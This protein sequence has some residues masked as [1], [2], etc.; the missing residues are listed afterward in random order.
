M[1]ICFLLTH[2]PDP[3][4]NKRIDLFKKD[5]EV[6]VVCC[7]RKSQNIWNPDLV[8]A[9]YKIYDID[10]PSSQKIF[11]RY[12]M[13][14][15]FRNK[16]LK[17]LDDIR[18]DV[19]YTEGLD[20]LQ[21]AI[22]YKKKHS[23]KS[24]FYEVADLRESY[25][26]KPRSFFRRTIVNLILNKEKKCFSSVDYLVLTSMKFYDAHYCRLIK[27]N[28]VI[29]MPN[30]PDK[31]VFDDYVKKT[32]GTFTVGFIGGIRYLEQMKML[33][34]A[35]EVVGCKVL[36][37]GVGGTTTDFDSITEYCKNKKGVVFY[38]KYDYK[39]EIASIY[40]LVDCVYAVYDADNPNVRIALPN[41]LYESILCRLPI[42]VSK[43][44][45]LSELVEK[46][47]VGYS[48]SHNN[49]EELIE[50]L[51]NLSS[52]KWMVNFDKAIYDELDIERFNN[53]L[54]SAINGVK[55]VDLE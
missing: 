46:W 30:I 53:N 13:S 47:R 4:T 27:Q 9:K 38:G 18:P 10:L 15:F 22:S 43:G 49:P 3:R 48:V 52:K 55:T 2:I 54:L 37:A 28:H 39:K 6:F 7:R 32:S 51:T 11:K 29:Y 19:I 26:V 44:T 17:D 20:A 34:D 40:G 45:Y 42:I 41:K 36:F 8:S 25:L 5:H 12:F 16:A 24:I 14:L 33:V 21:T 31:T 50:C 35:A 23:L 1:K